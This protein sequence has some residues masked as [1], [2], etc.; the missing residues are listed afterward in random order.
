MKKNLI[1]RYSAPAE[2][3]DEGWEKYSLPIGNG[4]FG[5][6]VF[7]GYD[8]ERIQ[9]T[10]N[11]FANDFSHGGVSNFGEVFIDFSHIN[12]QNYE[13][14]LCLNTGVTYSKYEADGVKIN[15][16][17]FASYPD[18]V[19]AYKIIANGGTVNF[20]VSLLIPYLGARP[21]EEG[22]RTGEI[23]VDNG[24][25]VMR[26]TLPLKELIYEARLAVVT[27]GE[28]RANDDSLNVS[29]ATTATLFYTLDTSYKLCPEVFMSGCHK[30]LGEDPHNAVVSCL[31]NAVN[32]GWDKLYNRHIA[33]YTELIGR[34]EFDLGGEDDGRTTEELLESYQ[35]G[36]SE[37]YLEELY[38]AYGRHL[39]VSSSRKG[40]PPASLQGVWTV[41]DK[42]PWSCGFWHNI[43]VQMNYWPAFN[44]NLAETFSAYADYWK[45]YVHQAQISASNWIK[46]SNPENYVE[47]DGECGW[48]IG[49]GAWMYQVE[50][51]NPHSHSGPGT[52]GLTSKM[53]WD[54]Y[55]FTR[56]ENVLK[57]YSYPAIHGMSKFLTKSVKN[58]DGR[59]L[60]SCSASPE[61]ILS[62]TWVM[63]HEVQQYYRTVG[64]A[65]D[66]Q[67]IYENACDD[68]KCA[69]T[70]NVCDKTTE[71]EKQQLS[72]YGPVQIGYSGQIK[73]Y[74]EEHFYGEIGEAQHRHLSQLVALVP[75][76]T[77]THS[78]PAWLDAAKLTLQMR[79]DK[80]TGWAL[81]HR[82][83]A[84]ARV[85]DGNHAYLLLQNLLKERTYPNL[86]DVHPPFQIDGNFG[87]T[88]GI[89]EMVLQ[90][91]E[92]YVSLL[93]ALPA[94][95]KYV[96]FSGLKARGNFTVSCEYRDGKIEHCEIKSEAGEKL[97]LRNEGIATVSVVDK[98]TNAPIAVER[99][100]FFITFETKKG[101]TYVISGF[102]PT[103]KIDVVTECASDWCDDGVDLRWNGTA[104]E[105]AIYRAEGNDSDY[106]FV[107]KTDKCEFKDCKYTASNKARLTYKIV[108]C[109]NGECDC[110][111]DGAL[112]TLNIA[113][114]L[115]KERYELRF[116]MNN[117]MYN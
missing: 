108:V 82:F 14:G 62:G 33:D 104:D 103:E 26:G 83:C 37:L 102:K 34:V 60:C 90:S 115:E 20:D 100:G 13:R 51:M 44:T 1:M 32:L 3:T 48:I 105:Y 66:Q 24:T 99:N 2:R 31:E 52:G 109:K 78:T 19:F 113:S 47:G 116:K 93:P 61:Q 80:S 42:S 75:G 94:A 92:G 63:Q 41:H 56:D 55:D 17:A 59:Y 97:I 35:K 81:A 106:T 40:T 88:A 95:W 73:E 39:L 36:N 89:T 112:T 25:L 71:T 79:G 9:F 70:L 91:H 65:F 87:A 68:L 111:V 6:S 84:W 23:S 50:G 18:K 53:F 86:W 67:F 38:Y 22:G 85:G 43:N 45:N 7:G 28:L 11:T 21:V 49:T 110:T 29:N 76:S 64:C 10:T 27:D 69:Q 101:G 15:R 46:Q 30:A 77:I 54:Y 5:A 107:A 12:I 57:E 98:E 117:K 4:Y 114:Q 72:A 74:D 58:Y 8:R 16:E 96:S